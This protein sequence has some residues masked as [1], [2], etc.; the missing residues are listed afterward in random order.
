M[1]G[2]KLILLTI[3]TVTL[4]LSSN[5]YTIGAEKTVTANG[6]AQIDTAQSKFG[7]ASGL[8]DG[9]GDYLSLA[10]SDDWYFGAGDFTIDFWVRF[11]TLSGSILNFV[12]NQYQDSNNQWRIC[13]YYYSV[14]GAKYWYFAHITGGVTDIG[15]R[16]NTAITTGSWHHEVLVRS[17]NTWKW[18]ED[19]AQ[20]ESSYTNTNDVHNISG[21]LFI[22]ASNGG[23][24]ATDCWLDELRISKG[25]ARWT[26]AFTPPSTSYTA[27]A[28]TVL[29]LHCD[30]T[31]G[32]TTFID[33][34]TPSNPD[35][36]ISSSKTSMS[37][38]LGSSDT[39]TI[40]VTSI[41]GFSDAVTLSTSWVGASPSGVTV[42]PLSPNPITPASGGSATSTLTV[43][44]DT[45]GSTG[46]YTLSVTGTAGETTHST[47]ISLT[48]TAQAGTYSFNVRAGAT[49]ITVTCTWSTSG[50]MTIEL[51]SP[52]STIYNEPDMAIYEKTTIA[53]G[54]TTSYSYLKGAQLTIQPP[55]T[56]QTWS[57]QL[58][59]TVTTYTVSIEVT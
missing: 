22:A 29:L 20:L 8:F 24:Y 21:S 19:G 3:L 46:T 35:F 57:L 38:N 56:S 12:V 26:S 28:N 49:K 53:A 1:F 4:L 5:V 14:S 42:L 23:G 36:T 37:I 52:S 34:S 30:G 58:T 55:T 16:F 54:G 15:L 43:A 48:I 39:S 17:G 59:T 50:S 33:S 47:T 25:V 10:D 27:D 40:T 44:V 18:F 32:S 9:N 2:K 13:F 7:G 31:D 51:V 41:A 45:F 11:D 6:N